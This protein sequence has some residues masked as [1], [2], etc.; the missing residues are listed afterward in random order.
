MWCLGHEHSINKH[1]L[2][3]SASRLNKGYLKVESESANSWV[4]LADGVGAGTVDAADCALHQ[5]G[6]VVAGCGATT[7]SN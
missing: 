3:K 6:H 2:E 1:G 5:V 7:E 4:W